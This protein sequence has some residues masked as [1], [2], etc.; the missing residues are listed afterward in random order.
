MGV[1][2]LRLSEKEAIAQI[3]AKMVSPKVNKALALY[4]NECI[5]PLV[6]PYKSKIAKDSDD[7]SATKKLKNSAT[8]ATQQKREAK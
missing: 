8:Q 1:G 2:W 3:R 6:F 7:R 5:L 4:P